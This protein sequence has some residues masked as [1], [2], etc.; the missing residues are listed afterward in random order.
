[1]IRRVLRELIPSVSLLHWF[2]VGVL[3]LTVGL[4]W[5]TLHTPAAAAGLSARP[6]QIDSGPMARAPLSSSGVFTLT[7]LH[8]ND[9]W[10]YLDPC[11]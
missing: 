4:G 3:A 10:G 1:M 9:T 7:V 6:N 5:Y 8:T 2:T 11:G